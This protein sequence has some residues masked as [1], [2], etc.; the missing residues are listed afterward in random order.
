MS[1]S[2]GIVGL[3]NVGKSTLFHALTRQQVPASNYPFCTIDPNIGVVPVPDARLDRIAAIVK[4]E[5][6]VPAVV[7]F[8]DIA[9]LVKGASCG[10]GLGNQFLA[11]IRECDAICEV[12]R[13]FADPNVAHVEGHVD[14]ASDAETVLTELVLADMV[15]VD[16]VLGRVRKQAQSAKEHRPLLECL[17]QVNAALA[18]GRPAREAGVEPEQLPLLRD[19]HLLTLKPMVYVLNVDEDEIRGD[20]EDIGGI[21]TIPVCAK[22]EAELADLEEG[23]RQE[24]LEE[25]GLRSSGLERLIQVC[26]R[27]LGLI[28]FFTAQP[29]EARAWTI[30]LGTKAPEAAGVIHSDFQRG[31]IRAEV[32][33]FSTLDELGSEVAVKAA[34]RM[35][36]E[37][38][39]YVVRDGDLIHFRFNV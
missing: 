9:G 37:G 18:A 5:K 19:F 8:V 21:E 6:V 27:L 11:H 35:R 26:Y 4:P 32:V 38:K 3:P 25:L 12:L 2:V 14:P 10:E 17:E 28:T 1:L 34:G 29:N 33:D 7:E 39:D 13:S 16:K 30:R 23:E 20:A 36:L 15:T 24:F 31:F 22:L